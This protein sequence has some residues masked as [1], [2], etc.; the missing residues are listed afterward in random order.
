VR[1]KD[2][3][4]AVTEFGVLAAGEDLPFIPTDF[5]DSQPPIP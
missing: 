3:R 5:T 4:L 2:V 1:R